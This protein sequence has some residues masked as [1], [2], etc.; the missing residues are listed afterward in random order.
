M[1]L[2]VQVSTVRESRSDDK[3][4]PI[5]SGT[6]TLHLRAET[7]EDRAAWLEALRATKDMFPRM[8]SSEMVGPGDTA[9]AVA[10]STER[11]RQR[12]QQEGVSE[13]A[14]ADSEKIV[15]AEFEALHKQ[16]VLSKQK[17]ALLV[18]TLRQLEVLPS[19]VLQ[20]ADR[21]ESGCA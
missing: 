11:L 20:V 6:K 15:R 13:A 14:I 5:F 1:R 17:H 8:S 16:L 2:R 3:R 18:E 19:T 4:F 21:I 10:V 12:L 7:R 9:A